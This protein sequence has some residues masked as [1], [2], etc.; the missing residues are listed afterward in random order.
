[1]K[2]LSK[3][4]INFITKFSSDLDESNNQPNEKGSKLYNIDF[5]VLNRNSNKNFKSFTSQNNKLKDESIEE[6]NKISNIKYLTTNNALSKPSSINNYNELIV[7]N[8]TLKT[9]NLNLNLNNENFVSSAFNSINNFKED[10]KGYLLGINKTINDHNN[11]DKFEGR[12]Q[13][14]RTSNFALFDKYINSRSQFS[15]LLINEEDKLKTKINK[16]NKSNFIDKKQSKKNLKLSDKVILSNESKEKEKRSK[17]KKFNTVI[18]DNKLHS[19]I[20]LNAKLEN[21]ENKIEMNLINKRPVIKRLEQDI[22]ENEILNIDE[23]EKKNSFDNTNSIR[24]NEDKFEIDKKAISSTNL[25]YNNS[26]SLPIDFFAESLNQKQNKDVLQHIPP[27]EFEKYK[28]K[29]RR[30][31]LKSNPKLVNMMKHPLNSKFMSNK[32]ILENKNFSEILNEN[33]EEDNDDVDNNVLRRGNKFKTSSNLYLSSQNKLANK[34]R[35]ND[36]FKVEEKNEKLSDEEEVV[37]VKKSSPIKENNKSKISF[38]DKPIIIESDSEN[39][40][41][42]KTVECKKDK[43]TNYHKQNKSNKS[44]FSTLKCFICCVGTTNK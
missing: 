40:K 16:D 32:F 9:N 27:E 34:I 2:N 35:F 11:I 12:N 33:Q 42:S 44:F 15:E 1:M 7:G 10:N 36:L 5:S 43:N 25:V 4:K 13:Q 28:G 18:S 26:H 19:N 37:V 31:I 22:K 17:K 41:N 20:V 6:N 8:M 38:K 29:I 23:I 39:E 14:K 30:S 24:P 21:K 3:N